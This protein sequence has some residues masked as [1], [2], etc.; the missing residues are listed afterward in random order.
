[1]DFPSGRRETKGGCSS[2]VSMLCC[3][4]RWCWPR[5]S[6]RAWHY[7]MHPQLSGMIT[8]QSV[9]CGCCTSQWSC[10]ESWNV[11]QVVTAAVEQHWM[12]LQYM[13]CTE[14]YIGCRPWC[15]QSI[16]VFVFGDYRRWNDNEGTILN[17][18]RHLVVPHDCMC[19]SHRLW[20][21]P[22]TN[23][24]TTW[25]LH[26]S[27]WNRMAWLWIKLDG[28]KGCCRPVLRGNGLYITRTIGTIGTSTVSTIN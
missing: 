21:M 25:T 8:R 9:V 12:A 22:L 26:L 15:C 3:H 7:S 23:C 10:L 2:V 18:L 28:S 13:S 16:F 11:L 20:G 17:L 14:A 19:P 27:P 24:E 1:M 6:T 5:C 4:R